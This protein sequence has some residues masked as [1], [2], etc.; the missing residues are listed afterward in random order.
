MRR[1]RAPLSPPPP[2]P[3]NPPLP[4]VLRLKYSTYFAYVDWQP[5]VHALGMTHLALGRCDV[6]LG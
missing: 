2:L 4:Q 5:T 3:F 6:G 1:A